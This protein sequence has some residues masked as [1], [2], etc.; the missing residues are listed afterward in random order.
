MLAFHRGALYPVRLAGI[1]AH[2][3]TLVFVLSGTL[4]ISKTLKVPKP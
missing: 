4:M 2:L 1:D 3:V